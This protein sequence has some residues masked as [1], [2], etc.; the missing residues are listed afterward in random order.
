MAVMV[1]SLTTWAALPACGGNDEVRLVP[2]RVSNEQALA[3]IRSC[4]VTRILAL[5]S[6]EVEL[7]VDGRRVFVR[8]PDGT[9]LSKAAWDAYRE[10]GCEIAVGM[11]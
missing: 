10:R 9:A 11:E 8:E 4:E 7:T 5:H 2:N 1:V 3:L 6:G